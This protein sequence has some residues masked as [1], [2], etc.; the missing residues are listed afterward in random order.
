MLKEK[1]AL[2]LDSLG[3]SEKSIELHAVALEAY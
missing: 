2:L 1:R 3:T